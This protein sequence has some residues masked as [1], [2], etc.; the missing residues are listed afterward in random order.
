MEGLTIEQ[1]YALSHSLNPVQ[2]QALR[3]A[4]IIRP[5]Q[6]PSK[7]EVSS[8]FFNPPTGNSNSP[9][10]PTYCASVRFCSYSDSKHNQWYEFP[11]AYESS[12]ALEHIGF[13]PAAAEEIFQN[14][15]E[16]PSPN[17]NPDSLLDYAYGH[18][19][20]PRLP[21]DP[22]QMMTVFGIRTDIQD[23]IL[24]PAFEQIFE[25]ETLKFWIRDTLRINYWTLEKVLTDLVDHAKLLLAT[26]E[27]NDTKVDDSISSKPSAESSI[28]TRGEYPC[29]RRWAGTFPQEHVS[30]D[31]TVQPTPPGFHVLYKGRAHEEEHYRSFIS[32]TGELDFSV[33]RIWEGGD[34][35]PWDDAVYFATD[36]ETAEMYRGYAALRC[37]HSETMIIRLLVPDT[38]V[39]SLDKEE[40]LYSEDWKTCVWAGR[41]GCDSLPSKF[42][43]F[44][45]AE[46]VVGHVSKAT[47]EIFNEMKLG[48][49][50]ERVSEGHVLIISS[51]KAVQWAFLGKDV[52]KRLGAEV[53]G[54]IHIDVFAPR[55]VECT[56]LGEPA[57]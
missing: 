28:P 51:G 49:V 30:I 9:R 26:K 39:A 25:T 43:D 10:N 8:F 11:T 45:D 5:S 55:Q 12:A 56:E 16:R 13:T 21:D 44:Y 15:L 24:D 33:I 34:F 32:E 31:D 52:R 23:A 6:E 22:R 7:R 53:K 41:K 27:D 3:Q 19:A 47:S 1:E 57:T 29:V 50:Q 20:R 37:K 14:Y 48:D 40:I 35:N 46:L 18:M 17:E 42:D 4:S 2:E 54:R 36:R 38:F